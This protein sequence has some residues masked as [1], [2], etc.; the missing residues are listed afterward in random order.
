MKIIMRLF[1]ICFF[2]I[3]TCSGQTFTKMLFGPM[4]NDGLSSYGSAWVDYDNDDDLDMFVTSVYNEDDA[5]Y[6][7]NNNGTFSIVLLGDLTDDNT[8]SYT[9]TWGDVNNDGFIDV[10]VAHGNQTTAHINALYLNSVS[11][12]FTIV[13][14]PPFSTDLGK[15]DGASFADYDNDG[16]LDLYVSNFTMMA[17]YLYHNDGNGTFTKITSGAPVTDIASTASSAWGDYD[18][19]ND[20]DLFVGNYGAVNNLYRNDGNGTFTKITSGAIVTTTSNSHGASWGD[21]DNDGW[22]DLF[23][24]RYNQTNLLYKNNGN[25]TFTSITG[26]PVTLA[27]GLSTGS[28]WADYDND[29]D[30]DLFVCNSDGDNGVTPHYNEFYINNGN[31]TFS[32][33]NMSPITTDMDFGRGASWGDYDKDGDL[34][35]HV[36]NEAGSNDVLYINNGNSNSW[37]NIKCIGTLSNKSAIGARI[38]VKAVVNGVSMWQNNFISAQTGYAGMNS[39]NVEFGF[40]NATLID[41]LI[42]EWPSGLICAYIGVNVNQYITIEENCTLSGVADPGNKQNLILYPNPTHGLLKIE[43]FD[44]KVNQHTIEVTDIAGRMIYSEVIEHEISEPYFLNMA[45]I[46]EESGY[47]FVNVRSSNNIQTGK[48]CLIRD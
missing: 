2:I 39:L 34:D 18:N 45:E 32:T 30:L 24:A 25:G 14:T 46:I 6:K 36:S 22:L 40:G 41:S 27:T 44:Q 4:V 47:Y 37:I 23:V 15:S 42:V 9:S 31:G 43:F 7:N 29:G 16:L 1:V 33:A 35:L 12:A 28:V 21:Y 10:F 3:Q 13:N 11:G 26:I 17:N 19:D 48:I 8:N 5:M 38:K 20:L